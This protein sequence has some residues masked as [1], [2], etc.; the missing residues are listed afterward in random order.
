MVEF[1]KRFAQSQTEWFF[2]L[3]LLAYPWR[4]LPRGESVFRLGL[5]ALHYVDRLLLRLFPS[6]SKYAWYGAV[7][8][9]ASSPRRSA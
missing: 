9:V 4:A 6:L 2:L 3:T 7:F 5:G 1:G 8:V